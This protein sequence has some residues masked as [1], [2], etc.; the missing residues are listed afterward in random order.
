M[1]RVDIFYAYEN[2]TDMAKSKYVCIQID[3]V[4]LKKILQKMDTVHRCIRER[5]NTKMQICKLTKFTV[6]ASLFTNLPMACKDAALLEPLLKNH[7]VNCP[8]FVKSTR[9]A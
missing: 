9:Q 8:K 3:M 4:D 1:E 7:N 5:A 2:S 6:F